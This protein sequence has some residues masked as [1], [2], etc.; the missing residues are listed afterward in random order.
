MTEIMETR[1]KDAPSAELQKF[2]LDLHRAFEP[3]RRTLL[4]A[5]RRTLERAHAGEMPGY[6]PS[7]E[8]AAGAW[9]LAVPEWARD[10]R[11]QITGPA[12]NAKLLVAMCN[13]N[14]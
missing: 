12:D 4:A 5:R 3:R 14:D 2:F 10:Q 8:A 11:N 9:R 13:T 7:S 1:L 6:L